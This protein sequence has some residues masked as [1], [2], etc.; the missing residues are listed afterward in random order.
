MRIKDIFTGILAFICFFNVYAHPIH[1]SVSNFEFTG[2][3]S[4]VAVKLF[5]DDLQLA[6]YHNYNVEIPLENIG[7]SIYSEIIL[8][9]LFDN[10]FVYL[11]KKD[12]FNLSYEGNEFNEEA[13]WLYFS[14]GNLLKIDSVFLVNT[15]FLDIY[16]D[17]TNLVIINYMGKQT[18]HRF[19]IIN[20][21][22]EI[23]LN[24]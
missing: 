16:E 20:T 15:I 22:K 19:N 23:S 7:D 3:T 2:E 17:Q 5:K 8:K 21:E 24:E 13:I 12:T 14:A 6:I 4:L 9:Y 11:S 10:M 1:V 18:G